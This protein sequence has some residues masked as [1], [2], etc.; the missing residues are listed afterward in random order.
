[1]L[2]IS[3]WSTYLLL[4][5]FWKTLP[6]TERT[7]TGQKLLTLAISTNSLDS[8]TTNETFHQSG[9]EHFNMKNSASMFEISDSQ[10]FS[11]TIEAQSEPDT[12]D[13]SKF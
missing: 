9:K 11:S 6:T 5:N 2:H 10:I 13:E 7:L 1:M 12:F 4:I 3:T 8:P